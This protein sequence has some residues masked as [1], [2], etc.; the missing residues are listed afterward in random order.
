LSEKLSFEEISDDIDADST[1]EVDDREIVSSQRKNARYNVSI[2]L[3][4]AEA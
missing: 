1:F 4:T 2:E 3:E